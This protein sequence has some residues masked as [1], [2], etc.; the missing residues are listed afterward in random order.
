MIAMR[1]RD[2]EDYSS[3]S[4]LVENII[5]PNTQE[6]RR[7]STEDVT[8][9]TK[10]RSNPFVPSKPTPIPAPPVTLVEAA[11]KEVVV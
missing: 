9:T 10:D 3:E 6:I 5:P 8:T 1:M 11:K 4:A 7:G 2:Y